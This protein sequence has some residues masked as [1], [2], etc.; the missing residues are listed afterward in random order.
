MEVHGVCQ[1]S[2]ASISGTI[3]DA[4]KAL[5]P[6]V[7]VTATNVDTSIS[8]SVISNDAG[9]YTIA[10]L[11]PG[12]YKVSTSLTGFQ[13]QTFTNIR[14]G[15]AAQVRLNFTLEVALTNSTAEV[16]VSAGTMLLESTSSVGTPTISFQISLNRFS[17]I[18]PLRE[19]V[20]DIRSGLLFVV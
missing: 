8:S 2:N 12:S 17:R 5:V 19:V 18:C 3:T 1:S 6:G 4:S 15:N 14:L 7:T 16:N 13:T 11:L 20:S 9:A 10:G